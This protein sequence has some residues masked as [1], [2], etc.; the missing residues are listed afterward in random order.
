[1]RSTFHTPISKTLKESIDS[2]KRAIEK[3]KHFFFLEK[4]G[5]QNFII[6]IKCIEEEEEELL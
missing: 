2:K 6:I 1:L 3:M 4:K 5:G